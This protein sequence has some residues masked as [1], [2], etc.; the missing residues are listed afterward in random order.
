MGPPTRR[1]RGPR[2]GRFPPPV[3]R[4][5]HRPAKPRGAIPLRVA[6]AAAVLG[7][8]L[9]AGLSDDDP[10]GITTYSVLGADHGY[11]LLWVVTLS[12]GALIVFHELGARMGIATGKGFTTLVGERHG[13][14]WTLIALA[15]LLG[16][17]FGTCCAEFAGIATALDPFDVPAAVAAPV[18]AVLV[19]VLVMAGSF[20]KVEH[21]LLVLSAIFVSYIAAGV[22]A[23]PD[24]GAAAHGLLVPSLPGTRDG[25]AITVATVGT[26]LA[27]WGLLFVQS[28]VVDKGI[29]PAALGLERADVI[30]GAV[31]TGVIGVFVVIACAATINAT[32][33]SIEDAG[34]AAHALE[35][36]AGS[37]ASQLFSAGLLGAG[38]LAAAVVPLSTA[39]TVAE[40]LGSD[41]CL[42]DNWR[43]APVFH[44]AFVAMIGFSALFI[45]IPGLPLL[46]V[47]VGSQILNAILLVP[48]LILMRVMA[49]DPALMGRHALGRAGRALTGVAILL[50]GA[51]VIA[52]LALTV[53]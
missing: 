50:I 26:T 33:G 36:L 15:I 47:L 8:G 35:P 24:W 45:A 52:L 4:L 27:P 6:A 43:Q 2:T 10:A 42:D 17:N 23:H 51:C 25:L 28:S 37:A 16:A 13:R 41:A 32:G 12:V 39:Y 20:H 44:R 22:L 31:L 5:R 30:T 53:A 3:W 7:P 11:R 1:A 46:D 29:G 9:L 34:D 14:R 19:G 21:V 40:A 18:A 48:L 38:L 49:R